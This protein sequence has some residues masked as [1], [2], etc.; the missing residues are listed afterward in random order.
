MTTQDFDYINLVDKAVAGCERTDSNSESSTVC[1]LLSNSTHATEKPFLKGRVNG[2]GKLHCSLI[3]RNCHRHPN[4]QQSPWWSVS[5]CQ[6]QWAACPPW[7][8]W[9]A[10]QRLPQPHGCVLCKLFY[11]SLH[12]SIWYCIHFHVII[13]TL[14]L[15]DVALK[16]I[17]LTYYIEPR[18]IAIFVSDSQV[19]ATSLD[20][21]SL[22]LSYFCIIS[23]HANPLKN[24]RETRHGINLKPNISHCVYGIS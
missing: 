6:H 15:L 17:L 8:P 5:S 9:P 19:R 4:L 1:K 3:L 7:A 22:I 2:C 11:L 13:L 18:A 20:L 23:I 10:A 14:I 16:Q 24:L 21:I 12:T